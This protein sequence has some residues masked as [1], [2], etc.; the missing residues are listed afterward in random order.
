MSVS[1]KAVDETFEVKYGPPPKP[2]D[3][4][5]FGNIAL[6]HAVA[7]DQPDIH[8]IADLIEQYPDGA[9][10]KNQF[11]RWRISILI[12]SNDLNIEFLSTMLST[13]ANPLRRLL[14]S[15]S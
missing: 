13:D 10:H 7:P 1:P 9:K 3:I 5:L 14:N 15:F 4:D 2:D 11:G 12:H 8:L 6:H